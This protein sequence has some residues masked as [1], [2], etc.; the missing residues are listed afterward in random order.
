MTWRFLDLTAP[1]F[2]HP[3]EP[4]WLCGLIYRGKRH[5]LSGPPEA[6][7]TLA[8]LAIGLEALRHETDPSLIA[9]IDFESGPAETRRL[10]EDLGA[11]QD[12]LSGVL[13]IE[14]DGSP[15]EDDLQRCIAQGVELAII[16]AAAGAYNVTGL[17]EMK[18]AD[19]ERFGRTWIDPLWQAGVA[20]ILIDHVVKKSDERGKFAIGGER[21]LGGV[22]VHLGL[23][24]VKQLHRGGAGLIRISTLK[25]RPA[26]LPRPTAA[27]LHLHSDPDTH[28][29][30]WEFK[31]P[32][33]PASSDES[34]R[35]TYLME[36]LSRQ[37]ELHPDG[38]SRTKLYN[39]TS[40]RREWL[41][42][43][44]ELLITEGFVKDTGSRVVPELPFRE[45]NDGSPVPKPFPPVPNDARSPRSLVPPPRGGNGNGTTDDHWV[46]R[47][48][49]IDSL[50]LEEVDT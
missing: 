50:D 8:A 11:T 4:P 48:E 25:D 29:I 27:E 5:S 41:V 2:A 47:L 40:G 19:I 34:F 36:R 6:A 26:W 38:L 18:R 49:L 39:L 13:Y 9:F 45:E 1:E 21:K 35:P 20:T 24:A 15:T 14:P 30:A 16:D 37:L 22:D 44:L 3:S 33:A 12:E 28:R 46:S 32:S 31:P 7:K 42:I 43:G 17:D 23:T 10:L